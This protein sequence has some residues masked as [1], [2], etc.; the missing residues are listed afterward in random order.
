MYRYQWSVA[1]MMH[2][3]NKSMTYSILLSNAKWELSYLLDSDKVL[4]DKIAN[5]KDIKKPKFSEGIL[6]GDTAALRKEEWIT[7]LSSPEDVQKTSCSAAAHKL[8]QVGNTL[9]AVTMNLKGAVHFVNCDFAKFSIDI[10]PRDTLGPKCC[11]NNMCARASEFRL[12]A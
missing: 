3:R 11:L 5:I 6:T 4:S 8:K 1:E 10:S 2:F 12:H 9:Y 7:F